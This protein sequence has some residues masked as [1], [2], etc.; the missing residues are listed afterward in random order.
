MLGSGLIQVLRRLESIDSL[1]ANG[2]F[3]SFSPFLTARLDTV[4]RS[5]SELR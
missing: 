3:P 1:Q 5:V 2:G 4:S